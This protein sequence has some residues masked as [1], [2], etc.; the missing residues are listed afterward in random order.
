VSLQDTTRQSGG[1]TAQQAFAVASTLFDKG[2]LVEAEP[3]FRVVLKL[4]PNHFDSLHALGRICIERNVL[5]EA[6]TLLSRAVAIQPDSADARNNLGVALAK[7]GRNEDAIAEYKKAM[8]LAPGYAAAH[9]NLANACSATGRLNDAIAH[10]TTALA[11]APE[12]ADT[13]ND[14]GVALASLGRH[15][16]AVLH[17]EEAVKLQ[18]DFA[19]AH[20]NLGNA[21]NA[22]R[23]N[24]D[25]IRHFKQAIALHPDY[26]LA[27]FNLARALA[28]QER[29]D[30]AVKH[31]QKALATRPDWVSALCGLG[32][33][34]HIND[35][36]EQALACYERALA[37][38]PAC[39]EAH[40]G[41]GV[42]QEALGRLRDSRQ[43]FE[44]A[45]DLA[46]AMPA[47][48]R[49]LAETKRFRADDPQLAAMEDLARRID[50]YGD[51]QQAALH[52]ALGKAYADL[53]RYA[54]AFEHLTHGNAIKHRLDEYDER[55]HLDM[56]RHIEKVFTAEL[57][58]Q[59]PGTGDPSPLPVLIVSMPR[60]G[61]TLIEQIL[62]S[63]PR[64]FGAGELRFLGR[65]TKAFRGRSVHEYFPE[66]A[67]HLSAEQLRQ[68]GAR[69]VEQ[70][71]FRGPAAE[72]V[73]DKMPSNYLYIGLIHMALPN[74]RII[75]ARRDPLDTC[76][77]CFTHHFG[78][79]SFTS[80][81]GTL[82]RY[83]RSYEALMAHWSAV[84]PPGVM[85][86]V[87]YEELVADFESHARRIV[88]HC[89]MDWNPRCL[90]FYETKRPVRTASVMQVREPI[91]ASSIGRWRP[92]EQWLAP[93]LEAL[94]SG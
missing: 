15:A 54:I 28:K 59:E 46:P 22:E 43:A 27:E 66:I 5:E 71:R 61:S 70:L 10:F 14:L 21:L 58:R 20:N 29:H 41:T 72:R 19:I 4:Q 13:H 93:L 47:Y 18:P 38:D 75:H 11:L 90:A 85:L 30:E 26:P 78:T 92:Y 1:L 7:L 40:H 12:R 16:E 57:L 94:G 3:I 36:T 81:L 63:H 62:A 34:L 37:L 83:Y 65:A 82:G 9:S 49:S 74:A 33:S 76:V 44:K 60:S 39:A 79:K 68:F 80:D 55:A 42:T 48:H 91:F 35:Q 69:Y 51:E 77:S 89:G 8:D 84:L 24:G 50:T 73:T 64:I 52:F 32:F 53:D 2:R 67:N 45:V 87:Q 6:Q 56:M 31:Y 23:R 17:F 86:E 88:A 25:A